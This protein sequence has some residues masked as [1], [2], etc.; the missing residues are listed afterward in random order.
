MGR[1]GTQTLKFDQERWANHFDRSKMT[2]AE[3]AERLRNCL[4]PGVPKVEDQTGIRGEYQVA[5]DCPLG[6]PR[7]ASGTDAS[8]SL[9]S[10]PQGDSLASS[11][12]ALGLKMERRKF[13]Q[14]V[15]VIEH[16]E[17]PSEN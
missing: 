8:G 2:M 7:P 10:D 5:Y 3:L 14:D 1:K 15:Y 11:L 13:L 12:D 16:V 9:P 6:I 17:R 4:G